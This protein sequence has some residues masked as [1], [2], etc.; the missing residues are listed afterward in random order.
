MNILSSVSPLHDITPPLVTP[1]LGHDELD[2]AGLER[3]CSN[4]IVEEDAVSS[5][6][7]FVL[8]AA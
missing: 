6:P 2:V 1:L 7:L 8:A 3:S 5:M 4:S